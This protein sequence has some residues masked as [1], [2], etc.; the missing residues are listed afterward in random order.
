[1]K[2]RFISTLM[3]LATPTA[4]PGQDADASMLKGENALASSLW[5]I[6]ALHFNQALANPSI[7]AEAKAKIAIRLAE[8]L[9]REGKSGEALALLDQSFLSNHPENQF[10]KGQAQ[11]GLGRFAEAIVTLTSQLAN[12]AAPHRDEAAFTIASLQFSLEQPE[13]ALDTLSSLTIKSDA[14]V[15][16]RARLRQV[17]FFLDL[18]RSD[19][20]RKLMPEAS[21]IGA[22]DRSLATFLEAHLLLREGRAA[23][24]AFRFQSLVDQPEGLSLQRLHQTIIGLA[25]ALRAQGK[26]EE[27]TDLLLSFIQEHQEYIRLEPLFDRLIEWLPDS[28]KSTDPTLDRLSQW[29]TPSDLPATGPLATLNADALGAWPIPQTQND[30]LAQALYAKA[31]GV[32]RIGTPESSAEARRLLTRLR[33]ENPDHP[34]ANQ[35]LFQLAKWAL[36]HGEDDRA[37]GILDTLRQIGKSSNVQAEAA[38]LEAQ[39]AYANGDPS[40]ASKLFDEAAKGLSNKQAA[41]ARFNAALSRLTSSVGKSTTIAQKNEPADPVLTADLTLE[42]ALLKAVPAEKR[43]ALEE[44]LTKYPDHARAAEARI[45]AAEVSLIGSS[46]DIAFARVQ[47]ESLLADPVKNSGVAASRIK[48]LQLK[49]EDLSNNATAAITSAREI[50]DQF[51]GEP[52]AA[53]ATLI[54]GRNLFQNRSYNDARLTLEKLAVSDTDPGR[55]Q[56]AGL[57]AARSA[58]LVPTSQ[59]QQEAL[60]LFDKVINAKGS[61]AAIAML[62]KARLMIDMNRLAE[63]SAF[64]RKWMLTLPEADPLHLPVGFLL[65][66]SIY[67]QGSANPGSLS[68]ALSIYDKMIVW[69]K[70]QPALFNRLQ[71][72][73]G[74]TLEQIPTENGSSKKREK[75]AFIAYYSVLEPDAPPAE[76]HYFELCGFRALALL[77]KSGR[78]PAAIACAKR[79][80]SFKGPRAEEAA[81]RTSQLQLKHRIWED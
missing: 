22:G 79:I 62:E 11:I 26:T 71:Y 1:M 37:F 31:M 59:S 76:W 34:L 48:L 42:Q 5:E 30:L 17:E 7:S 44:F 60:I 6:A 25:D 39:N 10:W 29:I 81:T 35:A 50:I 68:E 67:A 70:N 74:K 8:A 12:P 36:S 33:V 9:V 73:R 64:L 16:A 54:L 23:D 75:E 3:L 18:N 28:P 38:F 51:P 69:A 52:A 65:A 41:A 45:A 46:P 72:L 43:S 58:A 13:A 32:H 57:L 47:L 14:A 15:G 80:A 24:A 19:E 66:E 78:W 21:T 20:A 61:L 77:E 27:A 2:S 56:A 55:A 4:L 53:E 40:R 49:I 63:A